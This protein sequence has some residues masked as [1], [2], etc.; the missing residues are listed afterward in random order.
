MKKLNKFCHVI[1]IFF[2][3]TGCSG[4]G[5][6][7]SSDQR[8]SA[9]EK[10]QPR[11]SKQVTA[12]FTHRGLVGWVNDFRRERLP[13]PNWP[14]VTI[15]NTTIA[16][17]TE[18]LD[19][20][21]RT[22]LN[23]IVIWGLFTAEGWTPD[24]ISTV[25]TA[26]RNQVNDIVARA[27][28]RGIKVLAGL[29]VYSWGFKRILEADPSVRCASNGDVLNPLAAKSWDY[30]RAVIDY[31]FDNYAID[32]VSAQSADRGRCYDGPTQSDV[33]YHAD[34]IEKTAAYI[35]SKNP[36][37]I[38]GVANWGLDMTNPNDLPEWVRMTRHVDYIAEASTAL[39]NNR[40]YRQQLAAAI[41]PA[42]LGNLGSP[43]IEPVEHLENSR[44]FVPTFKLA[45]AGL[46]SLYE[47]GGRAVETYVRRLGNAGDVI[48]IEATAQLESNINAD[49]EL[50]LRNA[51]GAIY[52]ISD[53]N[54]ISTLV[55]AYSSAESA[56]FNAAGINFDIV[57]SS[58]EATTTVLSDL[59][60]ARLSQETRTS[61]FSALQAPLGQLR[62]LQGSPLITNQALLNSAIE[63][64]S[65]QIDNIRSLGINNLNDPCYLASYITPANNNASDG[66]AY[67]LGTRVRVTSNAKAT[68]LRF[69]KAINESSAAHA[70][71]IWDAR[72]NKL[73]SVT[74]PASNGSGWV[75]AQLDTPLSLQV[76]QDY[77]VSVAIQSHFAV[78]S[79][80]NGQKLSC[81]SGLMQ[82]PA[83]D[84]TAPNG[85]FGPPG[86]FPTQSFNG[87]FYFVDLLVEPDQNEMCYLTPF[88]LLPAITD[89]TDGT[90]Y[91]LGTRIRVNSNAKAT[92]VRFW[93][94][95]SE[96]N[97]EH[98]ATFW[99]NQ[100]RIISRMTLPPSN[101]QGWVEVILPNPIP[102]QAG[103]DYIVSIGIRSHFAV[104]SV[105][106]TQSLTCP[107]GQLVAPQST[108]TAPNG[109]F[110]SIGNFPSQTYNGNYYFIDVSVVDD[111]PCSLASANLTPTAA[112]ATD[113]T[114]YELGTRVRVTKPTQAIK[115][116]YWKSV[117]ESGDPHIGTI[118]DSTGHK[119]ANVVFSATTTSGWQ[120]A[121]LNTPL[122]LTPGADYIVSVAVQS[123]FAVSSLFNGKSL[124][125]PSGQLLAPAS[126]VT[127]PNGV[128][129]N[130]GVFPT[131]SYNGNFYF[132]DL[133]VN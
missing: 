29:G 111:A 45:A 89:A 5:S 91:E 19:F 22:G 33:A 110:G 103:Q 125:C 12:A 21:Q 2:I 52:G 73:A 94:A 48:T 121:S 62:S 1:S 43:F 114:S 63:S 132:V 18:Q 83:T 67:E 42:V 99:D 84:S 26:R 11:S 55:N 133:I 82:A 106:T 72:G 98:V 120:E 79:A 100:G 69:W 34:I 8:K 23:E 81:P 117:S 85:I 113:G 102:L 47:D 37:Y 15:D 50:V 57:L 10:Q 44:Y 58:R 56:Y 16:D 124:A 127:A 75:E 27:H 38:V 9:F 49:T 90:S 130:I 64:L 53:A 109:V 112:D 59:L 129:G 66:S 92:S 115:L 54:A 78:S 74:L 30:Q 41:A 108:S 107:T 86:Q 70:G 123:H 126:T 60:W 68:H 88:N 36:A 104:A 76:G 122:N 97:A 25:D 101:T 20:M 46:K 51:I 95:A 7:D 77:I 105:F 87:N 17:I 93:K 6:L 119:L 61:F 131:Q 24:I 80:L 39:G 118:W 116:R 40:A 31:V 14:N 28:S 128:F 3:L 13:N 71:S 35:K 32:G 96:S 65:T 4:N